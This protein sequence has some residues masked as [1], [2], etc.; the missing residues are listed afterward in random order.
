MGKN[1][2]KKF[3]LSS[4]SQYMCI[5]SV[6]LVFIIFTCITPNFLSIGSLQNL[7]IEI[8][9]LLLMAGGITFVIYTGGIDLGTGALASCTCVLTG[10]YVAKVGNII[11]LLMLVAGILMGLLNGLLVTKLKLPSF[12]VTLC[13]TNF[14]SY[15]ALTQAPNGSQIIPMKQRDIVNWA[16]AKVLNIPVMFILAV[17]VIILLYCIQEYT[18]YGRTILAVG[19]NVRAAR[20]AGVDTDKAQISAF[21]ICGACSALSGALYAYKLKSAVPTVGNSLGLM[22]IASVALG[23]TSM[24]GGRGSVLRTMIGVVTI[25]AVTSGLNMIGVNALWKDIIIGVILILAVC[26][27]SDTEGRDIIVK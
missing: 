3:K 5:V 25:T 4:Y 17:A 6:V 8:S 10:L 14:W 20:I 19:A 1:N 23:G 16:T 24:A 26:L 15:I 21:V 11:L 7:M 18:V 13:T 9:P 22:A 2:T 12:I 27:N